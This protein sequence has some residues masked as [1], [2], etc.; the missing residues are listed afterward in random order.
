MCFSS[1]QAP[2]PVTTAQAQNGVNYEALQNS[3]KLNRTNQVTP[4]G[5][6][7]YSGTPG[8]ADDTLTT[9][10]S[11][12]L[13]NLLTGQTQISQGLTDKS[14]NRL[15]NIPDT[16]FSLDGAP[17]V[18]AGAYAP[19]TDN[20]DQGP[21]LQTGFDKG[22]AVQYDIGNAGPIQRGISYDQ[23]I[24]KGVN[25]DFGSLLNSS[26]DAAYNS[27]A[28][29]LDPR[30]AREQQAQ[31]S[32][33]AA[34]GIPVGSEAYKNAMA[35]FGETKNQA[36]QSAQDSATLAG[37]QLQNQLFGQSLSGGQFSNNAQQQGYEQALGSGAFGNDAQSQYFGQ[38]AAR[39]QANNQAA[40]QDFSQ[41]QNAAQF[42]NNT[43]G[44]QFGQNMAAADF[45]NQANTSKFN[46]NNTLRDQ[47]VQNRQ[48]SIN[49]NVLQRNQGFNELSAFLNGSPISPSSPTFQNTPTY[50]AAQS[51]P[52]AVGMAAQNYAAQQQSR[53]ALLSS[54][55]GAAGTLGGAKI[56][57]CWVAREVFGADDPKWLR[58]REWMLTKAPEALREFYLR[59]G[60]RIADYIS[61]KPLLKHSIRA[62]MEAIIG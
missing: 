38:L 44:Q 20:F 5:N 37:N 4:Y 54:I 42:F 16:P 18:R 33:L 55:F 45:A 11:P 10:L 24:Q 39:Q 17:S 23:N 40:G 47:D 36:Y 59:H 60:E 14:L 19:I 3:A 15:Q 26:R 48:Q 30:F 41:N 13:Q 43:A 62:D 25:Q 28:Q 49:E 22:G 1:P 52:D 29:Y 34:Q 53:A 35:Q 12:E 51:S 56:L 31:E 57:A 6:L 46:Q 50:S 27:Q 58:M 21:A 2:N 61:D 8:Q 32:Q 7:T 9:S